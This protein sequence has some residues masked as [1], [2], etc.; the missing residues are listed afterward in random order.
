MLFPS[1]YLAAVLSFG[2]D[3]G[4]LPSSGSREPLAPDFHPASESRWDCA[5]RQSIAGIGGGAL[6][7]VLGG[8]AGLAVGGALAGNNRQ[9]LSGLGM[10]LFG[11]VVGAGL[12]GTTGTALAV[13]LSSP[14][15]FRSRGMLPAWGGS[16]LGVL[17]GAAVVAV[18]A[19]H[20]PEDVKWGPWPGI[21]TILTTSSL[22]A[23]VVD[24][25]AARE[26]SISLGPWIPEGRPGLMARAEF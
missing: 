2:S 8:V 21:V 16:L 15:G 22:G 23:V 12:G 9:D 10:I 26:P 4:P 17:A 7:T 3:L 24:R 25:L 18:V 19:D 11:G 1:L 5:G 13:D 6:G 20:S 14:D